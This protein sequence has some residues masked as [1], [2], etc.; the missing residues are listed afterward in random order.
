MQTALTGSDSERLFE[1]GWSPSQ[2][3]ISQSLIAESSYSV[4][5]H[6]IISLRLCV[7]TCSF[8]C[9]R[10]HWIRGYLLT[11]GLYSAIVALF[12]PAFLDKA[13]CVVERGFGIST[14][15]LFLLLDTHCR[16][17][18]WSSA[19]NNLVHFSGSALLDMELLWVMSLVSPVCC[20]QHKAEC[21]ACNSRTFDLFHHFD[22]FIEAWLWFCLNN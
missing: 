7:F 3:L 10:L 6:M 11:H 2:P 14:K 15:Y 20:V 22:L 21:K 12:R 17:T 5:Q 9:R 18:H 19:L 13:W 8:V 4:V 1:N 16:E